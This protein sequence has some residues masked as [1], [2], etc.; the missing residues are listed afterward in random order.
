MA[1]MM[2]SMPDD[3]EQWVEQ[4]VV[5]GS[6]SGP[7]DYLLSL[8]ARDRAAADELAW[9]QS[10]IDKGFASGIDPRPAEK[11]FADIRAKHLSL[12]A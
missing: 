3:L 1:Q 4:R 9:L 5:D 12:H 6:F 11:I 8:M 10:E 7:G 2:I